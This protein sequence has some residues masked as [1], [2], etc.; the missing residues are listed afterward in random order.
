MKPKHI[1]R[2][3]GNLLRFSLRVGD[4]YHILNDYR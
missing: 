3:V 4:G 2:V 1:I